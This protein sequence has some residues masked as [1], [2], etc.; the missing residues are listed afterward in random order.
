V[1]FHSLL[2][3]SLNYQGLITHVINDTGGVTQPGTVP[4]NVVNYP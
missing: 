2:S 1:K 3:V 4:S